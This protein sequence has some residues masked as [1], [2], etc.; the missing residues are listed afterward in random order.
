VGY[1]ETDPNNRYWIML[2]SWGNT[3]GR[4]AGI[5]RMKMDMNYDCSYGDMGYAF[6]W[7]TLNMSYPQE[8]SLSN[9]VSTNDPKGEPERS[10]ALAVTIAGAN[11]QPAKPDMPRGS[12]TGILQKS[13]NYTA[14][15]TD[16]DGDDLQITFDWGDASTSQTEMVN[17]G[18][19]V[20]MP[21]T[22]SSA[23][24][25][26]VRVMAT[27][28][29]DAASLWSAG[30]TVKVYDVSRRPTVKSSDAAKAEKT[31]QGRKACPCSGKS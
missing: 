28:H 3:T 16:P 6:Y 4:P 29:N 23:G 18:T 11:S 22:W 10:E 14:S 24:T 20:R 12:R 15:A 13:Y 19:T 2:N 27:D 9:T 26:L 30:K 5:F 21:H 8:D 31:G 1:D 17:S 7:M 25:Y